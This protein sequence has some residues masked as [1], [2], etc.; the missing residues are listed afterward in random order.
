MSQLQTEEF[1]AVDNL[2]FEERQ[3]ANL[4][5][6]DKSKL[7]IYNKN[8]FLDIKNILNSKKI[9]HKAGFDSVHIM[10]SNF[11]ILSSINE[12]LWCTRIGK[13]VYHSEIKNIDIIEKYNIIVL[14]YQ[15]KKIKLLNYIDSIAYF[16]LKDKHNKLAKRIGKAQ[17]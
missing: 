6:Y 8:K 15:N 10:C 14:R 2:S 13:Y 11:E 3:Y 7:R 5:N 17:R 4:Q 1:I 12:I 9:G 16:K